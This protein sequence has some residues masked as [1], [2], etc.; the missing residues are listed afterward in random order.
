MKLVG[1]KAG[2]CAAALTVLIASCSAADQGESR[3]GAKLVSALSPDEVKAELVALTCEKASE[4]VAQPN[5]TD[6]AW[7]TKNPDK[8]KRWDELNAAMESTSTD[9][10]RRSKRNTP[11]TSWAKRWR[12]RLAVERIPA[13]PEPPELR[14]PEPPE[15]REPEVMQPVAGSRN[16][17]A[18]LWMATF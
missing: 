3:S 14:T 9:S 4:K 10:Q 7:K 1:W 17:R 16:E 8:A 13:T 11:R 5:F 12:A 6:E 15:L 18:L 2:V